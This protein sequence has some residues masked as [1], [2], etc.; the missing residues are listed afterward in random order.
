MSL[1]WSS[2]EFP[3]LTLKNGSRTQNMQEITM[4]LIK[5]SSGS[6]RPW[7]SLIKNSFRN[8]CNIAQDHR[9]LLSKVSSMVVDSVLDI[10]LTMSI[11]VGNLSQTG[12]IMQSFK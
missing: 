12:E 10:E 2:M 8:S 7:K 3:S 1:K 4:L 11:V 5:L 9:G 6:G